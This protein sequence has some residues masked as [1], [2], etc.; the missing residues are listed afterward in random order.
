MNRS[1]PPGNRSWP[2]DALAC[3]LIAGAV[4]LLYWRVT[5]YGALHDDDVYATAVPQVQAGLTLAG[6]RWAFTT[7]HAEFWHPVTWLSL[8][9]DRQLLGP[10]ISGFHLSALLLHLANSLL[11]YAAARR[12][13]G[14]FGASLLTA[15]LFAVHPLHVQTVAWVADR[16]DLLA[17]L[18][19][20]LLLLCYR[21]YAARPGTAR[22]LLALA[23][24]ALGL[25]SKPSLVTLPAALLF[26]DW[27]PLGRIPPGA[28]GAALRRLLAEKVPFLLLSLAATVVGYWA[29]AR[30]DGVAPLATL[31]VHARLDN[32]VV[33][34]ADYLRLTAWPAGLAAHYP[35]PREGIPF[36]QAA[37]ALALLAGVTGLVLRRRRR[38][39]HLLVGWAWFAGLLLP[40][41]GLIQ[42]G[43]HAM[44]D[45][46]SY[47]PHAGLFLAAS[48][49]LAR[50]AARRPGLRRAA[51]A[52]VPAL[53]VALSAA[54]WREVGFWEDGITRYR[55]DLAVAADSWFT[56][57]NLGIALMRQ[58]RYA[59]T[60][61]QFRA[62]L[63]LNPAS[64]RGHQSLALA[65]AAQ[66]R[67]AEAEVHAR[68]SVRL[69]P[70]DAR[71]LNALAW[72]LISR[73]SAAEA[74]ALC[75]E[76]ISLEPTLT[77]AAVNLAGILTGQGRHEEAIR[78]LEEAARLDPGNP[79]H[80]YNLAL[81]NERLG[82]WEIAAAGYR[83]A[84]AR[85]AAD[86]ESLTRLSS[87]LLAQGSV[88][89]A[90]EQAARAVSL[91]P[92]AP[93]ARYV[94]G[95]ALVIAGE[96]RRGAEE[97]AAAARLRPEEVSW[98]RDAEEAARMAGAA[99][100][101]P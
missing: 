87:V 10:G 64:S 85:G 15:I 88:H 83:R 59:E 70:R 22:Y 75:R 13:T 53:L 81:A 8:M 44:A 80:H 79:D 45:R 57:L 91:T 19:C 31:G 77:D 40:V 84:I 100:P 17:A 21:A 48:W 73:G 37:L 99:P 41:I 9:L 96:Y 16:K 69:A 67:L 98:R 20:F 38:H 30:A 34:Y 95:R 90:V 12:L 92:A 66:G 61:V 43:N 1:A 2:R 46:Y 29:Q 26:L 82:R 25:M 93:E 35:H 33:S 54:T 56:R 14:A 58:R 78:W 65:L 47:V 89:E 39:P 55:R 42:V 7:L 27:W 63:R 71:A 6:V 97:L 52:A 101:P 72:V 24:F 50:L 51:I 32:A 36:A 11:L 3:V 5:G 49:W 74:E 28:G 60:E 23:V 76:A 18:F 62:L 68:E 4:L 86:G 94:L